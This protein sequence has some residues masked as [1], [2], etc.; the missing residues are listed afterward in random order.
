M[1]DHLVVSTLVLALAIV[2]ARLL[3][4][5]ARTRNALLLCG[6]AKFAIPELGVRKIEVVAMEP[7]VFDGTIQAAAPAAQSS[8]DWLP[9]LW[10]AV[11]TLLFGRWLLLRTRT[12][13]AAMR[14]PVPA[15]Q[16]E[17][18]ALSDAR[19]ILGIRT[20]VDIL[21]S[22][23][24]EAPAVLRIVRPVIVLPSRGCDDLTDDELRALLLHELAHVARHDNLVAVF[25]SL[26]GSLLWFHPLVWLAMRQL[27]TTRE[28]ACD[29]RVA[30]TTGRTDTYLDALTK[31][32]RA[33]IAPRPAGA[34]C[35]AGANVKERIEHLMR[36]TTLKT[37]AWPHRGV[38][39][40][41]LVLAMTAA[42]IA[43]VP[44]A[45][46]HT[47]ELRIRTAPVAG[48]VDYKVTV[49]EKGTN[50][51][52]GSAGMKGRPGEE[53]TLVSTEKT[54]DGEIEIRVIARA[55]AD[56]DGIA[57]LEVR[58]DGRMVQNSVH[59]IEGPD[60][61]YSG[62][63]ISLSLK[64]ADIRDVMKTFGQITGLTFV[65]EPEVEATITIDVTDVPWDKAL[66]I[67]ARQTGT[68]MVIEGKTVRITK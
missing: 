2:A 67:I 29:E 57:R 17:L 30:E 50:R 65:V 42:A 22:P 7:R 9:I 66:D 55:G 54:A 35:M 68:K 53:V 45:N 1:T 43:A 40:A 20:A 63:P 12:V 31:V 58:R 38:V 24:C 13:A 33:I 64:K 59:T 52:I 51:S 25:T 10:A 47:Y 23:I 61:A 46:E 15:S 44:Q 36:Y 60:P 39:A 32:C 56:G 27:D 18:D 34:A 26:A 14:S 5:T 16:R 11:A 37:T 48:I 4:L 41:S 19:R 21:R 3:P 8:I 62:E 49:A 28:E 6:L